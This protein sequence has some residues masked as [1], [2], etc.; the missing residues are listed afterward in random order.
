MGRKLLAASTAAVLGVAV[1]I[2]TNNITSVVAWVLVV[3][4]VLLAAAAAGFAEGD[5]QQGVKIRGAKNIVNQRG[6]ESTKHAKIR[7]DSN[8]VTQSDR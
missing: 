8:D 5:R 1:N 3:A 4:A 7:G 2:A 6:K